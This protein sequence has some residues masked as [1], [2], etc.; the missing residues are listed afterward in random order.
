MNCRKDYFIKSTCYHIKL[1]IGIGKEGEA[2]NT[3]ISF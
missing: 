3:G 1:C 2:V